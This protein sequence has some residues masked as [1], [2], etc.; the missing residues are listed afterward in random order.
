MAM[1]NLI[2]WNV[3]IVG[4]SATSCTVTQIVM[5]AFR[6]LLN[7]DG[8]LIPNQVSLSSVLS[9]CST[10]C[11]IGFGRVV[12]DLAVKLAVESS[13]AYVRNSLIDMY[14]KC[15]CLEKAVKVFDRCSD[16]DVVTWNVMMMGWFE[17]DCPKDVCACNHNELVHQG[18]K[19]YTCMVDL[20]GRAGHLDEAM[21]FI[22]AMP[23]HPD[24]SV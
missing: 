14:Y 12:H 13:L 21:Q 6:L 19:Y 1:R 18:C 7:D 24:S 9:T 23:I 20:L 10:V 5:E 2:S 8:L 16:R 4:M 22:D 15:G 17:S 11:S 3:L